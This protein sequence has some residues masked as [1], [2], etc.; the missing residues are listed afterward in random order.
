MAHLA[1]HA[2]IMLRLR[3]QGLIAPARHLAPHLAHD[4]FDVRPHA[5]VK[6]VPL[7]AAA[8]AAA[9]ES[10][11]EGNWVPVCKPEDMPKGGCS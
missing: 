2:C 11:S 1:C 3:V 5:E 8:A 9:A 6:E 10:T 4:P 7:G